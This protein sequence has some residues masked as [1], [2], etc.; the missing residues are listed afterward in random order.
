MK[1]EVTESGLPKLILPGDEKFTSYKTALQVYCQKLKL[2][3]PQYLP[4]AEGDG[5]VGTVSFGN[6]YVK[7]RSVAGSMK[8]ADAMA[9][10]EALRQLGYLGNDHEYVSM[11][12]RK[13]T[14]T[15]NAMETDSKQI[16]PGTPMKVTPK[17]HL[18]Q[19][20]QKLKLGIPT[21][22]TVNV[23]SGFFCTVG[24]GTQE[25]KSMSVHPKKSDAENDA[26]KV[27]LDAA[28]TMQQAN[29]LGVPTSD[30]AP[31][32]PQT[33]VPDMKPEIKPVPDVSVSP[34]K[35]E[36]PPLGMKN[37]LQEYC[38][39]STPPSLPKYEVQ[40][41]ESEKTFSAMVTVNGMQYFGVAQPSKKSSET[42]AAEVA[43]ISLGVSMS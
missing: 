25:F 33:I 30:I 16:K 13:S 5:L 19:V 36:R 10:C 8:D 21:Y 11:R 27:A 43:L 39:K 34:V 12:K 37:R 1:G 15:D 3:V 2:Q 31:A 41:N 17:A 26:A 29:T 14:N 40:H 9:A 6:N 28:S 32:Q 22:N 20:T 24:V 7:C 18:N 4:V 23:N 35:A 38:Q 42:S